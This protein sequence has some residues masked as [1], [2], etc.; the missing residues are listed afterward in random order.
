MQDTELL[1]DKSSK[2]VI[3]KWSASPSRAG[4]T[5]VLQDGTLLEK[6]QSSHACIAHTVPV[7]EHLGCPMPTWHLRCAWSR[8]PYKASDLCSPDEQ[9]C[10]LV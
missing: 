2:F 10:V 4:I 3:D 1:E 9:G 7:H 5:A 6:V 8:I